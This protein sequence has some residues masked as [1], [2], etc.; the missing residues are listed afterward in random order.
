MSEESL[1][2]VEEPSAPIDAVEPVE[3][4][5]GEHP[6]WFK[7]DKYKSIEDQA[8]A[9][10]DLEKKF[11]GFTGAPEEY[12]FALS[13][14]LEFEVAEDDPL[15]SDFKEMA[16]EMGMSNE[17]F[18]RVANK[19]VEQLAAQ[20]MAQKELASEHVATQM[21]ALG[22]KAQDRVQNV[23]QWAKAQLGSEE[24]FNKFAA[25]LTDAGMVEVFETLIN[26]TGNAAQATSHQVPAAPAMTED[27]VKEMQFAV[28]E[29]GNRKM[30]NPEYAAKVRKAWE[31]IRGNQSTPE[32]VGM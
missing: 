21:K 18:N 4:V 16:K 9:Y 22:D 31:Q 1:V 17:A 12:E 8:K 5:E 28:D 15:L 27:Q 26:K 20:D 23:A 3:A 19:Y 10:T 24:L 6:E 25:G 2:V 11:G 32:I 29:Y 14:G 13:E 30:Q 7:A